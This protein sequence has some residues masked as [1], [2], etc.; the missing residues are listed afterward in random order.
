MISARWDEG[1]I[2]IR[3]HAGYGP[4]GSDIVCAAVSILAETL[5]AG[6]PPREVKLGPGLAEFPHPGPEGEFL[7]RG[8]CLLAASCPDCVTVSRKYP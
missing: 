1:G 7:W 6:L 5:G 4:A 8:L 3:G 2:T